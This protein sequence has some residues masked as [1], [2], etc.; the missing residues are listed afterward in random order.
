MPPAEERALENEDLPSWR[1]K[2]SDTHIVQLE[3]IN[4]DKYELYYTDPKT[5]EPIVR[6]GNSNTVLAR[7]ITMII[8]RPRLLAAP[9]PPSQ[10]D[11]IYKAE[12]IVEHLFVMAANFRTV[13]LD[14]NTYAITRVRFE[15]TDEMDLSHLRG[16]TQ[17]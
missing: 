15:E 14:L 3:Q 17:R 6:E 9:N 5:G 16:F 13:N 11:A 1:P 8:V 4:P 7:Y 12:Q 10:N 2:E